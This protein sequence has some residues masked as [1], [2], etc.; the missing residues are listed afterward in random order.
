V[1]RLALLAAALL[2]LGAV[3]AHA[4]TKEY[5]TGNIN[6]R[7]VDRLDRSQDLRG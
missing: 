7:I 3:P 1:K 2:A 6:A 4:V 5:S